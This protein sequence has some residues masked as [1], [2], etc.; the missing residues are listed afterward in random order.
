ME[1]FA[2]ESM[3]GLTHY[4]LDTKTKT[5]QIIKRYTGNSIGLEGKFN[6]IVDLNLRSYSQKI[7]YVLDA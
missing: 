5:A 6:Y 7:I 1:F 2:A 3:R 4:K